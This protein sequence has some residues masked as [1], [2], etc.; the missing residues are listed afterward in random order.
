MSKLIQ[1]SKYISLQDFLPKWTEFAEKH[2]TLM[3]MHQTQNQ[4]GLEIGVAEYCLV[5]EAHGYNGNYT[6]FCEYC[7]NLAIGE[8]KIN[9]IDYLSATKNLKNFYKFKEGLYNHF[10][11]CH[12]KELEI[13]HVQGI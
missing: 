13:G 3:M 9:E 10:M 1:K 11:K 7:S 8:S 5:G 12:K 2:H 4:F 6:I